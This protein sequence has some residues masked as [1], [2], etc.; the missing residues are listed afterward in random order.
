M[1]SRALIWY[2]QRVTGAALVVLLILHFWVEHFTAGVRQ[3]GLTFEVVQQRFFHN[4][5][6]VAVDLAFL[7]VALTHGLIG[8]RNILFDSVRLTDRTRAATSVLLLVVG[9]TVAYWGVDAL[10]GN[11]HLISPEAKRA[12][13][14]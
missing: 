1:S 13:A 4:P 12:A 8:L 2:V 10:V 14:R 7:L 5:W 6:F 9:L 11:P 3:G